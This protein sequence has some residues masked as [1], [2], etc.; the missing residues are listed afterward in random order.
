MGNK[1]MAI[2]YQ[3]QFLDG[4]TDGKPSWRKAF[5][6]GPWRL[7]DR[8]TALDEMKRMAEKEPDRKFRVRKVCG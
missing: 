4:Y 7:S 5:V 8:E 3:I 2:R 1:Q 6:P